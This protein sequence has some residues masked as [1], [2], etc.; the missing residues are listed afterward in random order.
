[1]AVLTKQALKS[2]LTRPFV[3]NLSVVAAGTVLAQVVSIACTPLLTRL[4]G[5]PA[6]GL[7]GVFMAWAGLL[8]CV[9]SGRYHMAIV[10]CEAEA[11]AATVAALAGG[12][13]VL[14]GAALA[15]LALVFGDELTSL[16][17][18]PELAPYAQWLPAIVVANGWFAVLHDWVTRE[19]KFRLVFWA[20]LVGAIINN[21]WKLVAGM[22]SPNPTALIA[23]TLAMFTV[24]CFVL[25]RPDAKR[26]WQ[27]I[28]DNS[29]RHALADL[30][31]RFGRLPIYRAPKDFLN[32]LSQNAPII[33]L[34]ALFSTE[35]VGFFVLVDRVLRTPSAFVGEAFRRVFYQKAAE[36]SHGGA[37]LHKSV[38]RL[39]AA[40]AA[41][42][43]L[44]FVLIV[45][46]GPDIFGAV[47]GAPWLGAGRYARWLGITM[48]FA[49]I[50]EPA[51]VV[52]PVLKLERAFLLFEVLSLG[53]RA[54][55]LAA[56]ALLFRNE[57]SAIALY[58]VVSS[59]TT[60][61][62]IGYV[63]RRSREHDDFV[64]N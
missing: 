49:F 18:A 36:I 43:V 3:R 29:S 20:A 46:F 19:R 16:L 40:L 24:Q 47:F 27:L 45:A 33:M 50:S 53:L 32:A 34:S 39:T 60:L 42:G 1:M 2:L 4:Y 21:G 44:P 23:S 22:A 54:L 63:V 26:F 11:D 64:T 55:A 61:L 13:A 7:F 31:A 38:S 30:A 25:I 9:S 41:V 17:G 52:V 59:A 62:F 35:S 8:S 58:S 6:F 51:V 28:R 48:F 10:L 14:T 15:M 56:G 5:A 57:L 37:T 12:L